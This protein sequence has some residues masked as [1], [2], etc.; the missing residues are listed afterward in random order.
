MFGAKLPM[1]PWR[2]CSA[3]SACCA[4]V[5]AIFAVGTRRR[6]VSCKKAVRPR[7]RRAREIEILQNEVHFGR[8]EIEFVGHLDA[9]PLEKEKV[10]DRNDG[11]EF[12]LYKYGHQSDVG[13]HHRQQQTEGCG[14]SESPAEVDSAL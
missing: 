4:V 5:N 2:V 14:G 6:P 3:A 1:N 7:E 13:L 9:L 11:A 10:I 12:A 8:V